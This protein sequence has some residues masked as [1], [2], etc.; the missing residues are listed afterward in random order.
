MFQEII[1]YIIVL[2]SISYVVW[3]VVKFIAKANKKNDKTVCSSCSSGGCDGCPF[4]NGGTM[5]FEHYSLNKKT[6]VNG[7]NLL[8]VNNFHFVNKS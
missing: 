1:T 3:Q 4:A 6:K 8:N 5:S 7:G 2:S